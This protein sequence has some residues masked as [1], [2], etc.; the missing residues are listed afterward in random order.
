MIAEMCDQQR[1]HKVRHLIVYWRSTENTS[2]QSPLN[3]LYLWTHSRGCSKP[4]FEANSDGQHDG[5]CERIKSVPTSRFCIFIWKSYG[6]FMTNMN[7]ILFGM[8]LWISNGG[9]MG[10]LHLENGEM[11]VCLYLYIGTNR[12]I[13]VY[14]LRAGSGVQNL[15]CLLAATAIDLHVRIY[16]NRNPWDSEWKL[17][18]P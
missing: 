16:P 6:K 17:I 9:R 15:F 5:T 12:N 14:W 11:L 2:W 4:L 7:T 1:I 13:H 3:T 18:E 8:K 10:N